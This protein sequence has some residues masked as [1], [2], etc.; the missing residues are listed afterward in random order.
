MS[1][2]ER[3]A[4]AEIVREERTRATVNDI[5]DHTAFRLAMEA[6]APDS[7]ATEHF[8]LKCGRPARWGLMNA[9]GAAWFCFEHRPPK[10]A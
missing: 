5:F 8:C 6:R 10:P 1:Q 9:F 7:W 2:E 3:R 4:L